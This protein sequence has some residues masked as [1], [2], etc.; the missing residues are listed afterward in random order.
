MIRDLR[1]RAWRAVAVAALVA[2]T[3]ATA[4]A[5]AASP[6][7]GPTPLPPAETTGSAAQARAT[8]WW[9]ST[10]Q[11]TKAHQVTRGK[12]VKICLIDEG[13]DPSFPDLKGARFAG[14]TDL[15]GGRG[16]PDGLAEINFNGHGTTMATFIAGQGRGPGRAEGL[17]GTAPDAEIISVSA[18]TDPH[19]V[20]V[21]T[22]LKYCA[23][24]G[25]QVVNYSRGGT[26]DPAAVA[27]AQARDLVIVA[28]TGND[29]SRDDEL[30]GG[31]L[32][33]RWGVLSVGGVDQNRVI[34]PSSNAGGAHL[35]LPG[36]DDV[37]PDDR[38]DTAGV[39]VMGPFS[40][41]P[42]PAAQGSCPTEGF[43]GPG[44]SWRAGGDSLYSRSCGTS[45]A[46]AV[47]SG[48]VALV[49]AAH[50]ELNAANVVNRILR[51]AIPPTDGSKAP[52]PLYGYGLV[53]AYA[54]VTA[55]VPVVEHNPLG[56]CYTRSRG[57]W[58][59]RVTPQR[60][61][62]PAHSVLPATDWHEDTPAAGGA[63]L[64]AAS[65]PSNS[66]GSPVA[67]LPPSPGIVA[68]VFVLAATLGGGVLT[69]VL[70]LIRR[71]K[72]PRPPFPGP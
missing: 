40:V 11:V 39:A 45:E 23:D 61:E 53:D 32:V 3:V 2:A 44:T 59:P 70:L 9:L 35:G 22:T 52:S 21:E 72:A 26:A 71:R 13:V 63:A 28:A 60:P 20:S 24:H 48:I 65:A 69:V 31:S 1:T 29:G 33:G 5:A 18:S 6:V 47:V 4:E 67:G 66:S 12:G 14:G 62:P 64:P 34:D 8:Q 10:M 30:A 46:T 37:E 38:T 15:S 41:A 7:A 56:S 36:F 17:L 25:A 54:A 51:T 16:R 49:R 27:Y 50:P 43:Y 57:I 68:A 42:V 58:D 19:V 55:D